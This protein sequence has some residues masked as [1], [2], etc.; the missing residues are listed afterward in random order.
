MP[1]VT[2]LAAMKLKPVAVDR[3][4]A[5]VRL[6]TLRA[7]AVTP[8]IAEWLSDPAIMEGLNAPQSAMGL[9]A[10]RA[11][12]A[13]FDNL[14]RNLILISDLAGGKPLGLL[15]VDVDLRHRLGSAHVVIGEGEH[16]RM[17]V[18]Y[19]ATRVLMWHVFTE[20]KL[21]KLTFAPL[22]RNRA[23]VAACR[24]GMLRLE[25]ELKSHRIDGRT[26]ERVD[27][28]LFAMTLD[29]FRQRM[30][31]MVEPPVFTGPGVASRHV[32]D[33]LTAAGWKP[34]GSR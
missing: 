23:A 15:F 32:V 21:E 31:A 17:D 18:V 6:Q 27:Q 8:G 13:S 19:D 10:F 14:R 1:L 28:M 12:V 16:R 24:I 29:E 20:R 34:A 22:S 7:D 25:G 2:P 11:Y 5:L 4:G 9:D 30:T 3:S 33:H 26:G